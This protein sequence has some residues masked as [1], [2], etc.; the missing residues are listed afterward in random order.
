M[1]K[2]TNVLGEKAPHERK[3]M[4]EQS[5][6]HKVICFQRK[7][8]QEYRFR[9]R[10]SKHEHNYKFLEYNKLLNCLEACDISGDIDWNFMTIIV[11]ML[12]QYQAVAN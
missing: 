4:Q 5:L 2:P 1:G 11:C 3:K 7:M 6:S 12:L 8:S 9:F 10:C